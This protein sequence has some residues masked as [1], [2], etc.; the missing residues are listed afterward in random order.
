MQAEIITKDLMLEINS[1]LEHGD[2]AEI[3]R[4]TKISRQTINKVFDSDRDFKVTKATRKIL[5][6][7]KLIIAKRR[8]EDEKLAKI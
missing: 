8:A 3:V 5:K 6:V 2:K 7:S 4:K 1:Q